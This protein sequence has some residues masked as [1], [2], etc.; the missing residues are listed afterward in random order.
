[1]TD[2]LSQKFSSILL[3]THILSAGADKK[4][5]CGCGLDISVLESVSFSVLNCFHFQYSIL[6][7][8]IQEYSRLNFYSISR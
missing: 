6:F 2:K 7:K 1:M 5:G 8:N 4:A 3:P